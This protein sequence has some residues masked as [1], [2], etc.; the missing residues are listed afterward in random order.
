MAQTPKEYNNSAGRLLRI[1]RRAKQTEQGRTAIQT[2][3]GIFGTTNPEVVHR[4][5][6]A[7]KETL[8][9]AEREI[10]EAQGGNVELFLRHFDGFRWL[11][12]PTNLDQPWGQFLQ[13]LSN[14]ALTSL[15]F[16]A[17]ALP[18]EAHV[19]PDELQ[20]IREAVDA[21]FTQV[22]ESKLKKPLR[23]WLL[24]LLSVVKRSIDLYEIRGP[25]AFRS[26]LVTVTGEL[27]TYG[28]PLQ[29][30]K[31]EEPEV[32]TKLGGLF[33]RLATLAERAEKL[34]PWLEY[35]GPVSDFVVKLLTG[36]G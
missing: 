26:A 6:L 33:D 7:L 30:V 18:E 15:E 12:V 36:P 27:F 1:F 14:E 2:W 17:S 25:K 13:Y 16:C 32:A 19:K 34:R 23:D 29:E 22:R 28:Q 5:L 35:A 8:D 20:Q 10:K 9:D 24:E 4:S 21:L 31:E 3:S 11:V